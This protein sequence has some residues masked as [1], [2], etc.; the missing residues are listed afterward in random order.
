MTVCSQQ[1]RIVS[2]AHLTARIATPKGNACRHLSAGYA[3][4][5]RK[6]ITIGHGHGSKIFVPDAI[7]GEIVSDEQ[8]RMLERNK[9]PR[10]MNVRHRMLECPHGCGRARGSG[11]VSAEASTCCCF[12]PPGSCKDCPR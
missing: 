1:L 10:A 8:L 5:V 12:T 2:S 3:D 9:D 11:F 7:V 6:R 4:T